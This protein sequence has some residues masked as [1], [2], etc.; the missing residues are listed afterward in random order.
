MSDIEDYFVDYKSYGLLPDIPENWKEDSGTKIMSC[1]HCGKYK[2]KVPRTT[3]FADSSFIMI[4]GCSPPSGFINKS[5][6]YEA[7]TC[8]RCQK[9]IEYSDD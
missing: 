9:E 1:Y 6:W 5:S 4:S 3:I 7:P 8:K 2:F